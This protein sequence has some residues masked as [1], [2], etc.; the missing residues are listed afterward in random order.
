ME[1]GQQR[2][3]RE[4]SPHVVFSGGPS[5]AKGQTGLTGNFV[6]RLTAENDSFAQRDKGYRLARRQQ[7]SADDCIALQCPVSNVAGISVGLWKAAEISTD[8]SR[9]SLLWVPMR[10]ALLP[11]V[12]QAFP[13]AVGCRSTGDPWCWLF[14]PGSAAEAKPS[15]RT[16]E[17]KDMGH[18]LTPSFPAHCRKKCWLLTS[19]SRLKLHKKLK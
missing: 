18:H 9:A 11:M 16:E 2:G 14:V 13:V 17:S 12:Q 19:I 6:L 4:T 3:Q 1:T 10:Q 5:L 15:S 7:D 8:G